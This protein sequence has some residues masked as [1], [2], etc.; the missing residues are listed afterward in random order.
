[1]NNFSHIITEAFN[2]PLA[3]EAG[4]ARTFFSALSQRFG[5]VVQLKDVNGEILKAS[6]MK[7]EAAAF[8]PK[9]DSNRSYQIVDGIAIIPIDGSL[10]HKFG[11]VKPMSGMTGYDGI[12]Y[13]LTE[14]IHDPEVKAV[15]LDMNTPGGMVAGCFDL[16]D[17]IAEFRQIKPIW[18][19]GYDMH[20]SAGQM[21]ASACSRRLITQT[22]V[23]GSVGVILAHT[24]VEKML[25]EQGVEITLITA[26]AH[27]ADGNPYEALPADVREKW[28]QDLEAHRHT[29]ATKAAGY[30]GVSV[31]QVLNTE[32]DTYTGQ[33]AVDV[34]F[35][36]EVVNGLDAVQIMS[37]HFQ[38][39]TKTFD[40]GASMA[41]DNLTAD[42]TDS[43]KNS[44]SMDANH[45]GSMPT[46]GQ[47]EA[48][49][50]ERERC[51]GI[52]Q[53]PEAKDRSQLAMAL[54]NNPKISVEEAKQLLNASASESTLQPVEATALQLL[55]SEHG[56]PL[57]Q[58]VGGDGESDEQKTITQ[59]ASSYSRID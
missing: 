59:L 23:A 54:A 16:A 37:E 46:V 50:A 42:S 45:N 35:A 15:M 19:L 2:R 56:Q 27:K 14:A 43:Q 22:G 49:T 3:M 53:L 47:P 20:C 31:E 52:L 21:I 30:M 34:G 12:M 32:A 10:V 5:N 13:R 29:F 9:R 1:M 8:S 25:Q 38:K 51:M 28:Q 40:M 18:S 36:N 11:Y 39:E 33:A 4:Y 6:D 41:K 44:A 26:G 17:K 58:N 55:A 7:A 48:A 57:S 24:N